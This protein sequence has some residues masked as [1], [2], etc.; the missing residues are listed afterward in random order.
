MR[1]IRGL[2]WGDSNLVKKTVGSE[3]VAAVRGYSVVSVVT[4]GLISY[5]HVL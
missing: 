4:A 5:A 3:D 1:H 2:P